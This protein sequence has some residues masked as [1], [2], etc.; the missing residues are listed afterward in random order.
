MGIEKYN[1]DSEVFQNFNEAYFEAGT[2]RKWTRFLIL[3]SLTVCLSSFQFGYNIGSVN[4][5]TPVNIIW[6]IF[7]YFSL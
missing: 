1:I 6:L 2:N 4:S 5:V 7:K 3:C